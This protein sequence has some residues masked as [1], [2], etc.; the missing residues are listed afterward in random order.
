MLTSGILQLI[1]SKIVKKLNR[2]YTKNKFNHKPNDEKELK[3]IKDSGGLVY[4][5]R[6]AGVLAVSRTI[7]DQ[8]VKEAGLNCTPSVSRVP[9]TKEA[10]YVVLASDEL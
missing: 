5:G 6:I 2:K 3:R 1:Y 9:L 7:R 4:S 10:M 8:Q